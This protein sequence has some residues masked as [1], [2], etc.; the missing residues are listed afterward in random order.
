[1][2]AASADHFTLSDVASQPIQ[3]VFDAGCLVADA[4]LLQVRSL[5]R[6]LGILDDLAARLPDPRSPKFIH[7]SK[8]AL[9]TQQ[10]YQIL[11]GCPDCN[12]AQLLRDDPLFQILADVAPDPDQP[13]ASGSTLARF[14]YAY[15]R[16]EDLI[17]RNLRSILLG[18]TALW[19]C[20]RIVLVGRILAIPIPRLCHRFAVHH[21]PP[22]RLQA[23]PP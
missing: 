21:P 12:D 7:H 14:Q 9:L 18:A 19:C 3:V 1:M 10:V 13:L 4:G 6:S 17:D 22:I 15:G 5:E 8:R 16:V 20:E 23:I 11:A 2:V